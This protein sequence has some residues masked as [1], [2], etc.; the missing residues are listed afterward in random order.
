MP[1]LF[2]NLREE[3]ERMA[4]R[5]PG[6]FVEALESAMS[7]L[8]SPHQANFVAD[9]KEALGLD[10][11]AVDEDPRTIKEAQQRRRR[12]E[13]DYTTESVDAYMGLGDSTLVRIPDPEPEG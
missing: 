10:G 8:P 5:Q 1:D 13:K 6:P 3:V 2:G 11:Y 12:L 7:N 9:I 4:M